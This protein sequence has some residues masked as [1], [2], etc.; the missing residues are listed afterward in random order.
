MPPAAARCYLSAFALDCPVRFDV[1]E[2]YAGGA[3]GDARIQYLENA[4]C[5]ER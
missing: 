3:P 4:F 1:A 5:P 2:V